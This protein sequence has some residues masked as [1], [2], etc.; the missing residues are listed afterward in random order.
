MGTLFPSDGKINAIEWI[1][2][3]R[4]GRGKTPA[5]F[6]RVLVTDEDALCCMWRRRPR[7]EVQEAEKKAG[8]YLLSRAAIFMPDMLHIPL[9]NLQ[10]DGTGYELYGH[11]MVSVDVRTQGVYR[12]HRA[13]SLPSRCHGN[14][15]L[16]SLLALC[17]WATMMGPP[18][19]PGVPGVPGV[20]GPPGIKGD[21]GEPGARGKAFIPSHSSQNFQSKMCAGGARG[22]AARHRALG[23]GNGHGTVLQGAQG[24]PGGKGER[25]DP[26]LPGPGGKRGRKGDKG[27][28]GEQGVPG[29]DAPCPLGPDGLPLPGC[30]WRPAKVWEP[31]PEGAGSAAG[32]GEGVEPE[33][34]DGE[35]EPEPEEYEVREDELDAPRDY[36]DY[37]DNAHHDPRRD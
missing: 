2:L 15:C 7:A 27:D 32:R 5:I 10:G 9:L 20:A 21:K 6:G 19:A 1:F 36:D 25:G 3:E 37:T 29:L 17:S 33:P 14:A 12:S 13:R 16:C 11:E 18:G 23:A 22:S 34:E 30:G 26:G 8:N 28:R 31:R 24:E 4:S 35:P